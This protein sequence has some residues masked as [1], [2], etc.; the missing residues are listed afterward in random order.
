MTGAT[1]ALDVQD[2]RRTP[3]IGYRG[4]IYDTAAIST[5]DK[6]AASMRAEVSRVL[7]GLGVSIVSKGT[8]AQ[9]SLE[10]ELQQL[11]Y[12]ATQVNILWKV[13]VSAVI[14]AKA[15][16]GSKTVSNNFED[17]LSRDFAT[18]PSMFDNEKLINDMVSK[19]LQRIIDDESL[20]EL[21]GAGRS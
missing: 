10:I 7:S 5:N 6:V 1:L 17:R 21:L 9:A 20:S 13:E 19:L 15:S 12:K 2:Q 16:A 3:V 8:P 4:G 11:S 18:S 14:N